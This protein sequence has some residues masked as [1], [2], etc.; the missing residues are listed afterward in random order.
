[1]SRIVA[2]APTLP[3]AVQSVGGTLA[4]HAADGH[5][6]IVVSMFASDLAPEQRRAIGGL[7]GLSGIVDVDLP[8]SLSRGYDAETGRD[9]FDGRLADDEDAATA[10]GAALA[11][12]LSQL[13]PE[14]V[15]SPI[16]LT[17][18]IDASIVND[19]LD[20]LSVPRLRWLDLPY[21]LSRTP[22]AP[23]GAGEVVAVPIGEQLDR[24]IEACGQFAAADF[25]RLRDHAIAEGARLG[26][27]E[28]VEILLKPT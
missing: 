6:V 25:T 9:G 11:V 4:R 20:T 17:G 13:E 8:S 3:D 28:P 14:L 15:L 18:H 21:G 22:G 5:E 2:V 19:T 12:A 1:M 27:S 10:A 23:L 24:K 7:L 16:G 26:T